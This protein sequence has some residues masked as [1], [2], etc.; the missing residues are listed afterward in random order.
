MGHHWHAV[1]YAGVLIL[2]DRVRPGLPHLQQAA[3]PIPAHPR[4]DDTNHAAAD[5]GGHRGKEDIHRGPVPA[6][7]FARNT[8]EC[9]ARAHAHNLG[10]IIRRRHKRQARADFIAVDSLTHFHLA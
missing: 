6:H 5:R 7:L 9:V 1:D 4:H 10:L 3:G 2:A 8:G